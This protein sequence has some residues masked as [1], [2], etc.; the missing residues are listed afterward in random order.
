MKT[1]EKAAPVAETAQVLEN[2]VPLYMKGIEVIAELQ[3]KSLEIA[4][5]QNTEWVAA[6]KKAVVRYHSGGAGEPGVRPGGAGV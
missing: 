6:G 4:A 3:K 5:Q 1:K 2:F